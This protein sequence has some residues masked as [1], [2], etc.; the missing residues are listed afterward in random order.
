MKLK[1]EAKGKEGKGRKAMAK[2]AKAART[3]KDRARAAEARRAARAAG[4]SKRRAAM[5]PA[6]VPTPAI[7]ERDCLGVSTCIWQVR[8]FQGQG[9]HQNLMRVYCLGFL[10]RPERK[11]VV[12]LLP[13]FVEIT[14]S[15][16]E[17]CVAHRQN[18]FP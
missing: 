8:S 16:G 5:V 3:I 18:L 1:A 15:N 14:E 10:S 2:A 4:G 9:P 12:G 13:K 11:N 6:V 17:L 7:P